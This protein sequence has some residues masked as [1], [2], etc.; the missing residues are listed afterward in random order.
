[1]VWALPLPRRPQVLISELVFRNP[2]MP[3]D[4]V[5]EALAGLERAGL[6]AVLMGGWGVDALVGRQLRTHRDLDLAVQASELDQAVEVL[7]GL[8]F[9]RWHRDDSPAALG[10]LDL[11]RTECCRDQAM[12]A[13]DLHGVDLSTLEVT[14]GRVGT[15]EVLCLSPEE[16]LRAQTDRSRTPSGR[17]RHRANLEALAAVMA[18]KAG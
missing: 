15:R 17:R 5:D 6:R 16:Q 13:V 18:A 3:L 2:P 9:E 1:M 4:R 11:K 8:G 12:R 14:G 10:T 7:L